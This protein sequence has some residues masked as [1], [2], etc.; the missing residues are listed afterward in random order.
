MLGA[1]V[2]DVDARLQVDAVA[3]EPRLAG[4]HVVEPGVASIT[5]FVENGHRALQEVFFVLGGVL[6]SRAVERVFGE[7]VLVVD[8]ELF[9]LDG[10]VDDGDHRGGLARQ[11]DVAHGVLEKLATLGGV[12][13]GGD[14]FGRVKRRGSSVG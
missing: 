12:T 13:E 8:R 7:D 14:A 5:A 9:D 6:D 4:G 10:V 11:A 3:E 1:E 2:F